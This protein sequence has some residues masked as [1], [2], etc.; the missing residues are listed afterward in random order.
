MTAFNPL[1]AFGFPCTIP[2]LFNGHVDKVERRVVILC[3]SDE[4]VADI[5][6]FDGEA[7]KDTLFVHVL[8]PFY[9]CEQPTDNRQQL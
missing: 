4:Q 7:D 1:P 2:R 5:F 8:Y 9:G 6:I 3:L